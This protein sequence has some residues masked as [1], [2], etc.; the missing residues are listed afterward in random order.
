MNNSNF[1]YC[2]K[3]DKK[4]F[5]GNLTLIGEKVFISGESCTEYTFYQC[6]IC[7]HIWQHIE[8]SGFG[9]HGFHDSILTKP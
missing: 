8:D 6:N 5:H 3:C 7:G 4:K 1:N 2:V 9:G